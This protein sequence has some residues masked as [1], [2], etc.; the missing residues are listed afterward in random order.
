[1]ATPE[2][3]IRNAIMSWLKLHRCFCFIHDS[4]GIFD[5]QRRC[6]RVRHGVHRSVGIPDIIG[7]WKG[8]FLAIEVKA[9]KSYPSP[10][11]RAVIERINQEGG[12]AFVARS[13]AD[14]EVNLI[15]PKQESA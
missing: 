1:M 8:R 10:D 5:P 2:G 15:Q 14:C 12:I 13:I 4:V 11:Q 7:I 6:Y 9:P 3:R